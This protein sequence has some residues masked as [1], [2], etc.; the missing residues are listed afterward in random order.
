VFLP[1][2]FAIGTL[3]WLN[4]LLSFL[5]GRFDIARDKTKERFKIGMTDQ[6]AQRFSELPQSAQEHEGSSRWHS[7]TGTF[8][9]RT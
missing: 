1:H 6:A 5:P 3:R 9:E 8:M 4:E 7:E 2:G